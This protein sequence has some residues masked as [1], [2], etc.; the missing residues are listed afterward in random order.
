MGMS[1]ALTSSTYE[2][3]SVFEQ[4]ETYSVPKQIKGSYDVFLE[5]TQQLAIGATSCR[6]RLR[7]PNEVFSISMML[8]VPATLAYLQINSVQIDIP[9]N[10]PF[11]PYR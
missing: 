11:S 10:R 7:C 1:A 4:K 3:I 8:I 5:D 6:F 9:T 2:L